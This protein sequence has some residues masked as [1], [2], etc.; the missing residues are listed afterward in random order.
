MTATPRHAAQAGDA[1]Q[2]DDWSISL[3]LDPGD[4]RADSSF[5]GC[6]FRVPMGDGLYNVAVSVKTTGRPHRTCFGRFQSRC[7]IEFVGDG[8]PS[9][10]AG[11]WLFHD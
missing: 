8:E 11:G 1:V 3:Q 10:F 2:A 7:K 6:Q 5:P 4:S 9:T